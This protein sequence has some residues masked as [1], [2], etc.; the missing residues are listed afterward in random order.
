MK[1]NVAKKPTRS[2]ANRLCRMLVLAVAVLQSVF[3]SGCVTNFRTSSYETRSKTTDEL[4][5]TNF[6]VQAIS[7]SGGA[8]EKQLKQLLR[9]HEKRQNK[10]LVPLPYDVTITSNKSSFETGS[11][12][13]LLSL[14]TLFVWPGWEGSRTVYDIQTEIAVSQDRQ[15]T[16]G[17]ET[18]TTIFG[19]PMLPTGLFSA[20]FWEG[21]PIDFRPGTLEQRLADATFSSLTED[22]YKA[23]LAAMRAAA[24]RRLERGEDLSPTDERLLEDSSS[25]QSIL[26]ARAKHPGDIS[27]CR[28]ALR[29][30]DETENLMDIALHAVHL[31]IREEAA[32]CISGLPE[33]RFANL[34]RET[35]DS[36]VGRI[37]L[38]HVSDDS[39]LRSIVE[40]SSAQISNRE[41]ALERIKSDSVLA[42]VSDAGPVPAPLRLKAAK[43][44]RSEDCLSQ[45]VKHASSPE[46]R[47]I[48]I[49]NI[50]DSKVLE[51]VV[52]EDSNNQNRL[53][54]LARIDEPKALERIARKSQDAQVR[55]AAVR[56]IDNQKVL[57]DLAEH[58]E[59]ESV[60]A[61]ILPKLK[62]ERILGVIAERDASALVRAT[63]AKKVKDPATL[64]RIARND[65]SPEI[66]LAALARVNDPVTILAVIENDPDRNIRSIALGKVSDSESLAGIALN[67][68]EEH[69]R[70]AALVRVD[71]VEVVRTMAK[72]DASPAVRI[73]AVRK[74]DED[75][76]LKRIA[77]EDVDSDVRNEAITRISDEEVLVKVVLEDADRANRLHALSKISS[78]LGLARVA[79]NSDDDRLRLEAIRQVS[80]QDVLSQVAK[81]DDDPVVRIAAVAKVHDQTVIRSIAESD[82]NEDVRAE[83]VKMLAN[84]SALESI[85]AKDSSPAVRK[86]AFS[87]LS[88]SAK[89]RLA[90][91]VKKQ[92]KNHNGIVLAGFYLGMTEEEARAL[93]EAT[94]HDQNFSSSI[95]V[96]AG[97]V[98]RIQTSP[99]MIQTLA[100]E[101]LGLDDIPQATLKFLNVDRLRSE[102]G[103]CEFENESVAREN[104]YVCDSVSGERLIV[105]M[106]GEKDGDWY[107]KSLERE[108]KQMDE[109]IKDNIWFPGKGWDEIPA[110][111]LSGNS[112]NDKKK[113]DEKKNKWR[114]AV[115]CRDSFLAGL[116]P[117]GTVELTR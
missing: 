54:A 50:V 100:G 32:E 78:Q 82:A 87:R 116:P 90:D 59:S 62:N 63:A 31:Q 53:A 25:S 80:D 94:F 37:F 26:V 93:F 115:R 10:D 38:E 36:S 46:V 4:Q 95:D 84:D 106:G 76:L 89:L 42:I 11:F 29:K 45:L 22:R 15:S 70:L 74:L 104:R 13:K 107:I 114:A 112:I 21:A 17:T 43:R 6:R 64:S 88:P 1:N 99:A 65:S 105:H 92:A 7:S 66:R 52:F 40:D 79:T 101:V 108:W 102:H 34:V 12:G 97:R 57:G 117:V 77:C 71:D 60:R 51:K 47:A 111:S 58:D 27:Q 30:I 35:K 8:D 39:L 19:W 98:T 83:A 16:A 49:G 28:E 20:F 113:Y 85:Y 23:G 96:S 103:D 72:E 86:I 14:V 69:I 67:N 73:A 41:T 48:A 110:S 91:S 2:V 3:G 55:L 9:N 5:K 81:N 56:R 44:I 68:S 33:N 24:E 61:S 109:W 75:E 18:Y